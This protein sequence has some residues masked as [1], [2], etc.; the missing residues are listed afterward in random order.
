[1]KERYEDELSTH[2]DIDLC[3]WLFVDYE[4]SRQMI[5]DGWYMCIILLVS[6]FRRR[7]AS[8]S[9]SG[10]AYILVFFV[11]KRINL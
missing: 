6:R 1:L 4:K 11:F 3:G 9:F 10:I 8:N 7:P 2:S 5:I